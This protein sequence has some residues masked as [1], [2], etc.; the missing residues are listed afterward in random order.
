MDCPE[1]WHAAPLSDR[2][3]C[4]WLS[5]DLVAYDVIDDS[6]RALN[7]KSRWTDIKGREEQEAVAGEE[8]LRMFMGVLG[9][10]RRVITGVVVTRLWPYS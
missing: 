1:G 4:Y 7:A 2:T 6:C 5:R 10:F 9:R 8:V 3:N